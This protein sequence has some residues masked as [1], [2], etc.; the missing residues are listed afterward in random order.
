MLKFEK[1][2]RCFLKL[3]YITCSDIARE[4]EFIIMTIGNILNNGK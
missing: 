2:S 1:Q 4:V 3:H